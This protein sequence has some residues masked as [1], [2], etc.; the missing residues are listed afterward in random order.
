MRTS[1]LAAQALEASIDHSVALAFHS[2][3]PFG[4]RPAARYRRLPAGRT[5]RRLVLTL[6]EFG[7]LRRRVDARSEE[8]DAHLDGVSEPGSQVERALTDPC[9]AAE[10]AVEIDVKSQRAWLAYGV[11]MLR[12]GRCSEAEAALK[13]SE[14]LDALS[15]TASRARANRAVLAEISGD[16]SAALS[17]STEACHMNHP[18][19]LALYNRRVYSRLLN[20]R[21]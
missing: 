18:S 5:R 21:P 7:L 20:G 11:A 16:M 14:V 1:A 8:M 10:L 6:T 9:S 4:Y 3:R 19:P 13:R 17:L 15:E 12:M 2:F